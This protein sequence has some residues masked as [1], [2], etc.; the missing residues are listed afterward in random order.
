MRTKK[1][2]KKQLLREYLESRQPPQ[3]GEAEWRELLALLTPVS[4]DYLRELLHATSVPVLQPFDGVRQSTFE[5]LESSLNAMER[6][7][8]E[9]KASGDAP[10]ELLCRRTVIRAKDRARIVSRN[11]K[12]AAEKRRQKEEMVNWMLVWLENPG[13]FSVWAALRRKKSLCRTEPRP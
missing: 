4:E 8:G 5:D 7:Y 13:V 2:S 6:V 12:V 1:A 3:I 9:A 10:R 11:P